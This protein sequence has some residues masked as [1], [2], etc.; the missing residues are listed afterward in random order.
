M[1]HHDFCGIFAK[2]EELVKSAN[3]Y[4]EFVRSCSE[5]ERMKNYL[6][7]FAGGWADKSFLT[8]KFHGYTAKPL[9][10]PEARRLE[11]LFYYSAIIKSQ[12]KPGS[13]SKYYGSECNGLSYIG[14]MDDLTYSGPTKAE[15]VVSLKKGTNEFFS[16]GIRKHN[17]FSTYV[18]PKPQV[19]DTLRKTMVADRWFSFAFVK[20][21]KTDTVLVLGKDSIGERWLTKLDLEEASRLLE[22]SNLCPVDTVAKRIGLDPISDFATEADC[23]AYRDRRNLL[24]SIV[25]PVTNI[26]DLDKAKAFGVAVERR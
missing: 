10:M 19:L 7:S 16:F 17:Y 5:G 18:A 12:E 3:S 1:Q 26:V 23:K 6:L 2:N 4:E 8:Y 21:S 25:D 24:Q 14:S 9:H 22:L 20:Q 15:H 11:D 13:M